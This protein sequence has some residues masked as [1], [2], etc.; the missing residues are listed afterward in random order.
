MIF[1]KSLYPI[2]DEVNLLP[3]DSSETVDDVLGNGLSPPLISP[4]VPDGLNLL[5]ASIANSHS[6][7]S[8]LPVVK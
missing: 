1:S 7:L 6:Y 5:Y 2:I 3:G 8:L 4:S